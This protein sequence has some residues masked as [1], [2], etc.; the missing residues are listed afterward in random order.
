MAKAKVLLVYPTTQ[1]RATEGERFDGS[2]SLPYLAAALR[3][4]GIEVDILD[5]IVGTDGDRLEDTFKRC[6]VQEN[7]LGR[8]RMSA[9]HIS[10]TI[11]RGG[12]NVVGV[13]SIFTPQTRMALEVVR[14]AKAVSPEILVL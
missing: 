6:V 12:Y 14:A 2:L 5:A 8:I 11:A 1:L 7:G 13:T 9:D 4:A 10:Q 3:N